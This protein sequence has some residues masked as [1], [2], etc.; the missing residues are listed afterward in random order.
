MFSATFDV[1]IKISESYRPQIPL[2]VT[3][4]LA[5]KVA[6]KWEVKVLFLEVLG[7]WFL[8]WQMPTLSHECGS[9]PSSIIFMEPL[10]VTRLIWFLMASPKRMT[11]TKARRYA[12]S[13]ISTLFACS[14]LSLPSYRFLTFFF[15]VILRSK[16]LW[17]NL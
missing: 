17:S 6:M 2:E 11:L 7:P 3:Q 9:S 12:P 8:I 14:S 10:H 5:Q 1:L 4:V 15:T 13:S 16:S